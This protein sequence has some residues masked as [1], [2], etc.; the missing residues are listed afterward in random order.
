MDVSFR[1]SR[2]N[3]WEW[4]GHTGS[5]RLTL[6][7]AAEALPFVRSPAAGG[8]SG[9]CA[10]VVLV[11]CHSSGW[12]APSQQS[13]SLSFPVGNDAERP[14]LCFSSLFSLWKNVFEHF[15][16]GLFVILLLSFIS[17]LCI[18]D[19][20]WSDS[21]ISKYFL[22]LCN[23]PFYFLSSVFYTTIVFNVE[24]IQVPKIFLLI[25]LWVACLTHCQ[26]RFTPTSASSS[27]GFI[28]LY[29]HLQSI[30]S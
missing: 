4:A 24:D 11:I 13:V 16:I 18:P 7:E 19:A 15:K 8:L 27:K 21:V 9:G 23:L 3:T 10:S 20:S 25:V 5:A 17:S 22:P 30:L 1:F 29:S 14:F 12:V 6:E 28:V 26:P 2:A